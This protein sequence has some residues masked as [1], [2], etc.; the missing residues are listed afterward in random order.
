[1]SIA[2]LQFG[3]CYV[4]QPEETKEDDLLLGEDYQHCYHWEKPLLALEFAAISKTC[5]SSSMN[6]NASW[7]D[8]VVPDGAAV[9]SPGRL[10][11]KT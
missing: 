10:R 9:L 4:V 6:V 7:T 3:I 11:K 8:H 5:L 2:V 1:V